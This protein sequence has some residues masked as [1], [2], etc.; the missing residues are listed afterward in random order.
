M[1]GKLSN[2]SLRK[3]RKFLYEIGCEKT[4]TKGGH[5]HWTRSDLARPL[6]LQ[7]HIDPIPQFI[8]RQHLRYLDMTP[9]DFQQKINPRKGKKGS[10]AGERHENEP[11][12]QNNGPDPDK[13]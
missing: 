7:S 6:T 2:V 3:Y 4:R 9:D 11:P 10:K 5:E 13:P 1:S 12:H 8:I